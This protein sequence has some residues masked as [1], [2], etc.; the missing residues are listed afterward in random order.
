MAAMEFFS[1][2][3]LEDAKRVLVQAIFMG[4]GNGEVWGLLGE[5]RCVQA[6]FEGS[7]AAFQHSLE[8]SEKNAVMWNQLGKALF[9]LGRRDEAEQAFDRASQ[10]DWTKALTI[11]EYTI[12]DLLSK[13][14]EPC[15]KTKGPSFLGTPFVIWLL[16][17]IIFWPLYANGSLDAA[18][19]Y[20][21]TL[22]LTI[23]LTLIEYYV[24]H[25]HRYMTK[26]V[27]WK[28]HSPI[29]G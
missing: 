7:V 8:L 10:L 26:I 20:S 28:D 1:S 18:Q 12:G 23:I 4:F 2:G 16:I 5:V 6:N 21:I 24:V 3:N 22:V 14:A 11:K 13:K 15:C 17:A 29:N 19:F 9:M 25:R 27:T